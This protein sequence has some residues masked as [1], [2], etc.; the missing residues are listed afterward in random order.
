MK[1]V[2]QYK[3]AFHWYFQKWPAW[4]EDVR[5]KVPHS[6][7]GQDTFNCFR[8]MFLQQKQS[9]CNHILQTCKTIICYSLQGL[10]V[11]EYIYHCKFNS[12][13]KEYSVKLQEVAVSCLRVHHLLA[14]LYLISVKS[15][16]GTSLTSLQFWKFLLVNLLT[17][18]CTTSSLI[19]FPLVIPI[20]LNYN[21]K[22]LIMVS[23]YIT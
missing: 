16:F 19:C 3:F 11:E 1:T 13:N 2:I 15:L 7:G 10:Q 5:L 4:L 21:K 20:W 9:S 14:L 12:F 17:Y 6:T 22:R 23:H 18:S 8:Q